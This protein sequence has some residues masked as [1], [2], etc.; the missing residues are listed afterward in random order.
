MKQKHLFY[1]LLIIVALAVIGCSLTVS[2][3][4]DIN[5]GSFPKNEHLIMATVWVQTSAEYRALC[6]QAY[7]LAKFRL[8][9]ALK[10][11]S[12][13]TDKKYAVVVDVDETVLNNI[14]YQIE[15]ALD[16]KS[17]PTGWA[18]WVDMATAE[19]I[20]GSVDFLNY[21]VSQ[22]VDVFY[23]TNRRI[24]RKDGTLANL[25]SAG[26]PQ[27]SEDH[28]FMRIEESGKEPR[29]Q[30]ILETHHILLLLGD[31]LND[32]SSVFEKESVAER[33][34][35]VDQ[36]KEEFGKRFILLPNPLYGEW[37]RAIYDYQFD[38]TDQEKS[39]LRKS[40]LRPH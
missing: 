7:N 1:G 25:V 10:L 23:V 3:K 15:C 34:E 24:S 39:R 13:Q 26:F 29:R 38:L 11:D 40:S 8:D 19:Q 28:L 16:D 21:T 32:F 14:P 18:E 36:M 37:A 35:A 2:E 30:K 4:T 22:G 20:A 27:A 31:N 17:Y 9:H 33:S 12:A 5:K 6:Y